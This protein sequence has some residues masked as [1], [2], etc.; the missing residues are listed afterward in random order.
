MITTTQNNWYRAQSLFPSATLFPGVAGLPTFVHTYG[1]T[2][3]NATQTIG[4]LITGSP[5]VAANGPGNTT[6][7]AVA[8]N[9]LRGIQFIGQ[10]AQPAPFNFGIINGA[11]CVVCSANELSNTTQIGTTATPY[12]STTLFGF[13]RYKLTDTIQASVQLNYGTNYEMNDDSD[14]TNTFAISS[15]NPYIPASVQARM[16]AA[17]ITNFTFS[18]NKLNNTNV[19][20]PTIQ[21]FAANSI[22]MGINYSTRQLM[23]GVFTLDGSLGEDWSW[24]A[25]IQHSQVREVQK[26]PQDA[27]VSNLGNAV[28][29]IT[30]ST[31]NVGTSGLP[32]GSVQCRS[33]LTSPTNGCVPVD[34]FGTGNITTAALNYVDPGRTNPGIANT[35]LY[36]MYQEVVAGSVEGTLPWELPAGKIAVEF[37]A[38]YRHE[39]Q[40]NPRRHSPGH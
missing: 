30:V 24:N 7:A 38:E 4:G 22:G 20:N 13:A 37:G 17:G 12:H 36:K 28:D 34:L 23:R 32:I 2:T 27:L 19:L 14:N 16:T 29:A 33:T 6:G 3:G 1:L 9:S 8:A 11:N 25:Y 5:A 21:D 35:V 26:D 10:N 31:A 40:R 39:Q 15:G 18:S